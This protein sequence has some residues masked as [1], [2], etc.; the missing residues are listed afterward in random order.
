M[1]P[2]L[3]DNTE[4]KK[5][6][7]VITEAMASSGKNCSKSRPGR[8][9]ICPDIN[10]DQK[11]SGCLG[12]AFVLKPRRLYAKGNSRLCEVAAGN[13]YVMIRPG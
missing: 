11:P 9:A 13:S 4:W 7:T 6:G 5:Q 3:H 2:A 1:G 12:W 8:Q 10:R